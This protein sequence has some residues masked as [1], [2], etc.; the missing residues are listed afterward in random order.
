MKYSTKITALLVGLFL[1][2]QIVG[3]AFLYQDLK[4]I[5]GP[6]G[7][8]IA[9]EHPPTA[10]GE[11]PEVDPDTGES[12][13][14][15]LSGVFIGTVLLLLIIKFAK[16]NY[17]K[18]LFF[19]AVITT[20]TIA[21]G[22][23]LAPEYAL[24]IALFLTVLKLFRSNI[25]IHN[26]TELLVYS[27]IAVLFVPLFNI[28]WIVILLLVIS[29]YDAFAV[30]QSRHMIKLAKFQTGSR[31]FAGFLISFGGGVKSGARKAVS[32]KPARK[33]RKK[34]K[35]GAEPREAI[36]GGGDI[37]FPLI[38]AGVVMESM[39]PA[40]SKEMA[41]LKALIIPVVLAVVL[42]LLLVRGKEGRFYPAMPFLTAGC[43]LGWAIT[44][45]I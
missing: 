14:F 17:W 24:I 11:R 31:L 23:F 5:E 45:L 26:F 7:E 39:V 20:M 1:I 27:G 29:A 13:V 34:M 30:W 43:L 18:V 21:L 10:I 38:F 2:S 36:L 12:L 25:L 42:L 9:K 41:F 35:K 33:S 19:I 3:L 37:A 16:V 8:F 22:V 6:S 40:V 28:F 15:V 4:V 32:R 44:L